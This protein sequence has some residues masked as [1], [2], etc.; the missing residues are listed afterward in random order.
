METKIDNGRRLDIL[1]DDDHTNDTI[2]AVRSNKRPEKGSTCLPSV[3]LCP[4]ISKSKHCR[5][6][7]LGIKRRSSEEHAK[8]DHCL[9]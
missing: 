9:P 8:S 5:Y 4:A 7:S 3:V 6:Y 2:D 1:D